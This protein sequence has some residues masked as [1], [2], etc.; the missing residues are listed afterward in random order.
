[1]TVIRDPLAAA[2]AEATPTAIRIAVLAALAA[3]GTLA[4]NIMLPSLP[5]IG[6]DLA[7]SSAE[8]TAAITV[9]LA[10]FAAG[11]LAIG[12]ISDRFGRSIPVVAGLIV[13][14]AG[15]ILCALANDLPTLLAGRAV[16]AIG[17][18]AAS[19][20]SR[21]IARDLFSGEALARAL[22][23]VTIAMATAPGF[24]PLLGGALDH[25]WGW[26]A[27]FVFVAIF[28]ALA[29]TTYLMVMGETHHA[30]R[31]PINPAAIA[32]TYIGL[33]GDR[34]FLVP[35][36]SVSLI[37][38]ALFAMF[39]AMPRV[40]IDD[41]H[42]SPIQL[43]LFFAGTVFIVFAAGI[44]ATRLVPKLGLPR[45]LQLALLLAAAGGAGVLLTGLSSNTF[46]P[47]LICVSI[48]LLGMGMVNPLGTA[49]T[50]SPFGER[51]G[52]ASALLGFWQMACAAFGVWAAA[53]LPLGA[54]AALGA[55]LTTASALA[56]LTYACRARQ[57]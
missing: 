3:V 29:A 26:R 30:T 12:P 43:G 10:V 16:Q 49:Q 6:R 54:M 21:A 36:A 41:L 24:S 9:F 50:L 47:F 39:S 22:S 53:K 48:F 57:A 18:C 7:V 37:M 13:F 20:L 28:G 45:A 46:L 1:M 27:G 5:G 32:R 38:G 44:G 31:S 52:A 14:V 35:A 51:A 19:V 33:A 55:V 2:P 42:F 23:L 17:A 4:T 11:Q 25:L 40:L 34:R 8:V 15:T 56:L